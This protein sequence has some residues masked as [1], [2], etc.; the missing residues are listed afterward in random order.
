MKYFRKDLATMA[1]L[2]IKGF[3]VNEA[4][5]IINQEK[6]EAPIN[7]LLSLSLK[8]VSEFCEISEDEIKSKSRIAEVVRARHL[9]F[10]LSRHVSNTPLKEIGDYVKRNHCTVISGLTKVQGFLDVND[11]ETINDCKNLLV[12][13]YK[14]K[15]EYEGIESD[16]EDGN[17][18]NAESAIENIEYN[19]LIK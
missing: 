8:C 9:F 16:V 5:D 2:T 11:K 4:I 17:Y 1:S 19:S 18:D 12:D 10:Y 6:L 3:S 14:L 13:F 15:I 7:G